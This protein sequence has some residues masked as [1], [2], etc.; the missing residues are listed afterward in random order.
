MPN[1]F[2]RSF[3]DLFKSESV[4][5][6][7]GVPYTYEM[8][9]K[10]R[11]ERMELPSLNYLTQAGGRFSPDQVS[12][13]V[14]LADRWGI[15]FYVMYG[16]TEATARISYLPYEKA[17]SSPSSI[18]VP[19]PGGALNIVDHDGN[20][21]SDAF[22]KGEL[23]YSGLNVMMGYAYNI[24]ELGAASQLNQ[25]KTGDIGYFDD[26]GLF[27]VSGRKSRFIKVYGVRLDLDDLEQQLGACGFSGICTGADYNL[28]LVT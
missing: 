20:L 15:R 17:L 19:I 12:K 28:K 7:G 21:V 14:E 5:T 8:L 4:T 24:D 10:L 9:N 2:D 22:E 27:Y 1:L 3:W 6:F 16:Q 26:N 11:F 25:L 23:V 18:G 13:M